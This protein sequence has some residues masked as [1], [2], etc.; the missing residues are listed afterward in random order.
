MTL[1][2]CVTS[3]RHF[4][5]YCESS[6]WLAGGGFVIG[7][8]SSPSGVNVFDVYFTCDFKK[9]KCAAFPTHGG[10]VQRVHETLTSL[11]NKRLYG[12]KP[13]FVPKRS[14]WLPTIQVHLSKLLI[15]GDQTLCLFDLLI[16]SLL[17]CVFFQNDAHLFLGLSSCLGWCILGWASFATHLDPCIKHIPNNLSTFIRGR[18]FYGTTSVGSRQPWNADVFQCRK[19]AANWWLATTM[20]RTILVCLRHSRT[21]PSH[22]EFWFYWFMG[23]GPGLVSKTG[24]KAKDSLWADLAG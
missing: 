9:L 24:M 15:G 6:A 23:W 2:F 13:D 7:A 11:I 22:R 20:N 18:F 21:Q 1:R 14:K 16:T 3:P 5:R 4:H 17:P 8:W 10:K 19:A 12:F